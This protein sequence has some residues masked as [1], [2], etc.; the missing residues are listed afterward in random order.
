MTNLPIAH[1]LDNCN[2]VVGLNIG[3]GDFSH[4]ILFQ[5]PLII[6]G[7][8]FFYIRFRIRLSMKPLWDFD[9]NCTKPV[10]PIGKN[11]SYVES[12]NPRT[13]VYYVFFEFFY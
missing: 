12:S 8:V 11:F 7:L 3:C 5:E 2:Y 13:Y 6:L 1:C 9:R 10:I 4:F